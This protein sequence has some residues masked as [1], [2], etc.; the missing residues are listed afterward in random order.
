MLLVGRLHARC[1][2]LVA[3][4]AGV[5]V[6]LESDLLSVASEFIGNAFWTL[7]QSCLSFFCTRNRV[8]CPTLCKRVETTAVSSCLAPGT[9]YIIGAAIIFL[10]ILL[11]SF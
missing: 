2:R 4:H 6:G 11:V 3:S 1:L 8:V 10:Q 7:F 9:G 5:P